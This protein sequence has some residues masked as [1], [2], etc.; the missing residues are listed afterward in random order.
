MKKTLRNKFIFNFLLVGILPVLIITFSMLWR[1]MGELQE[2]IGQKLQ[3]HAI[4]TINKIDRD[5]AEVALDMEAFA[6]NPLS[7]QSAEQV[8]KMLNFYTKK[9]QNY[10]LL[11]VADMS[12]AIIATNDV[13]LI[14]RTK[15]S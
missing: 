11:L 3:Q 1:S 4:S 12:G 6:F 14:F 7:L 5:L 13:D 10:D 8:K 2:V 15:K 9:Y